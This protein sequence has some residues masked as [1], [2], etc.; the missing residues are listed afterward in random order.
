MQEL[1]LSEIGPERL[2]IAG[3]L[4]VLRLMMKYDPHFLHFSKSPKF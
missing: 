4:G 3:E 1:I 2:S